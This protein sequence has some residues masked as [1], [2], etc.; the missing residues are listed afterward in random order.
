MGKHF[1]NLNLC[2]IPKRVR[3]FAPL[4]S[5]KG[6]GKNRYNAHGRYATG[7]INTGGAHQ[8]CYC[9]PKDASNVNL[10]TAYNDNDTCQWIIQEDIKQL[11]S[12]AF[13]GSTSNKNDINKACNEFHNISQYPVKNA[14]F[15][16]VTVSPK[17]GI[18]GVCNSDLLH[19][20]N[21]GT[22]EKIAKSFISMLS[23]NERKEVDQIMV[24]MFRTTSQ[25]MQKKF[26]QTN[27][28][29]RVTNLV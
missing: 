14:F 25:S 21:K 17:Y 4:N 9:S 18:F 22:L 24:C 12:T 13:G 2:H 5:L 7:H 16:L 23:I 8:K 1:F 27:F 3:L 26:P 11:T 6:D 28:T 10:H 19:V 29:H 15:N 20:F